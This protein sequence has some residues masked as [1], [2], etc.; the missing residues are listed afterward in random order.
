M[1]HAEVMS[2][3][4]QT[5]TAETTIRNKYGVHARPAAIIV[6][7]ARKFSSEITI[8]DHL[9]SVNC[10]SIMGLLN[11]EFCRGRKILI[12]AIGTDAQAAV[13]A[14]L[15]LCNCLFYEES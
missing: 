7:T 15:A 8:G 11:M 3:Q 6:K 12:S 4:I 5:V 10:K 9:G 14:L 1:I 13:D 2:A